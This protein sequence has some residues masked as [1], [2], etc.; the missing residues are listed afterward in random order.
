MIFAAW[1]VTIPPQAVD[2]P[3]APPNPFVVLNS[4]EAIL[5]EGE[6]EQ[7]DGHELDSEETTSK[8]QAG[9]SFSNPPLVFG[10]LFSPPKDASFP[11]SY[12][13]IIRKKQGAKSGSSEDEFFELSKTI[14]R[15]SKKENR[16]E[17]AERIKTQGSQTPIEMSYR[18]NMRNN[19]PKG[20]ITPS[21]LGK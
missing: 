16:E 6:I 21:P 3:K 15:K 2:I 4:I 12:A 14:G 13:D 20:V 7:R 11:P 9:P 17:E 18:R 19:P 8:H 5:E 1:K 10:S